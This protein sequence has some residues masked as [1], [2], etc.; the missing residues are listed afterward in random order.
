[1]KKIIILLSIILLSTSFGVGNDYIVFKKG[2][3]FVA[4]DKVKESLVVKDRNAD[5]VIQQVLNNLQ[6]GGGSIKLLK[7]Q[8]KVRKYADS[9]QTTRGINN[10]SNYY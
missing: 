1:M 5:V 9:I 8:K 7:N 4:T 3:S 6:N 10:G 2:N